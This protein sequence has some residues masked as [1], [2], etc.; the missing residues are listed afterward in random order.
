MQISKLAATPKLQ[1]VIIKDKKLADKYRTEYKMKPDEMLSFYTWDRLPMETFSALAQVNEESDIDMIKLVMPLMLDD[2]GK[3]VMSNG[4][5]LP[6]DVLIATI[7][8]ITVS[9]GK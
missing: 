9:L 5:M 7:K 4:M 1:E 2:K 3:E 8:A 6:K